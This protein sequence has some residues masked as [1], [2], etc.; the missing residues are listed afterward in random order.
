[1][2]IL[3]TPTE[4]VYL[5]EYFV[6]MMIACSMT[7]TGLLFLGLPSMAMDRWGAGRGFRRT[8]KTKQPISAHNT[9]QWRDMV[10]CNCEIFPAYL[11]YTH[12]LCIVDR[13]IH[14]C[15]T[16]YPV[17][18]YTAWYGAILYRAHEECYLICRESINTIHSL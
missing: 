18:T 14:N 6:C 5:W 4:Y 10:M 3:C 7:T 11:H 1:M 9:A 12:Y 8:K 13:S 17:Y 2:Y 15:S 16:L